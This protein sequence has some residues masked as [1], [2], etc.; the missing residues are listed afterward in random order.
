MTNLE[1]AFRTRVQVRELDTALLEDSFTRSMGSDNMSN[2]DMK[3]ALVA[4]RGVVKTQG[5]L[6]DALFEHIRV[7]ETKKPWYIRIFKK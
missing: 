3:I 2:E 7:T 4:L 6:L 1:F 5:E